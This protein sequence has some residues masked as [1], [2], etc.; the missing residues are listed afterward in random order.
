MQKD[1]PQ[2]NKP[3]K[4]DHPGS[5]IFEDYT[6]TYS[7]HDVQP[8]MQINLANSNMATKYDQAL[9]VIKDSISTANSMASLNL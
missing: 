1:C 6:Y 8:Q 7:G 3:R 5:K 2:L 4:E 9:D